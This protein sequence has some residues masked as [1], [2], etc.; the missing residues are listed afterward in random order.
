MIVQ[1]AVAVEV[2][3]ESE[4]AVGITVFIQYGDGQAVASL[5]RIT[6]HSERCRSA[7]AYSGGK[8]VIE[9]IGQL[10]NAVVCGGFGGFKLYWIPWYH[11]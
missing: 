3:P 10:L 2:S 11:H 8:N 4:L 1:R 5:L 6:A 9:I 7:W